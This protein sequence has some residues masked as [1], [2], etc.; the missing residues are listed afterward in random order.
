M[1]MFDDILSLPEQLRWGI[2]REIALPRFDGPIVLLGMGGSA[3]AATIGT[4]AS[5][6]RSPMVV[7]QGYGLPAWA[8][9]SGASV[10][11]VS[12]SGN[13]EE[14]LSGVDQAL[15]ADLDLAVVASG[16]RLAE[17][18]GERDLPYV[19]VPGGLQPRAG[20]GYQTAAVT[21][22]LGAG[23][24][25]P[26]ADAALIE[27]ADVVDRL[28]DEGTG[29]AVE[30]GRDLAAGLEGRTAVI[31]GGRGVGSTAAYRWKTQINENAKLPAFAGVVPEMNH[32]EL[33]GWQP[34][35]SGAFGVIY[36]RDSAD[37]PSVARRLDL[38]GTVLSGKVR[39][40]G[41][42]LSTGDGALARF[43]S[44]AVVGDV[45][46]VAMAEA[47]GIDATP[48]ETLEAFKKMLAKGTS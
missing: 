11:A 25:I 46:S 3:M 23:G 32:N 36:L 35:T 40:I 27:A 30:L 2:G 29:G 4:L 26:E 14:V 10:V 39:R 45:A 6:P 5:A 20:V 7:H 28:L 24:Q 44:L 9:E 43:F 19:E 41:D 47:A 22:M 13:T 42:V 15:S 34:D 31:Y 12:Y 16:G 8:I 37:H 1:T 18:A 48:V 38:S 33:E 21:A 17:I